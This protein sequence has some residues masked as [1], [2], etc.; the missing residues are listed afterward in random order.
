VGGPGA[1]ASQ[2]AAC[3]PK[4]ED[5]QARRGWIIGPSV[6]LDLLHAGVLDTDLFAQKGDLP[7]EP[8]ELC[9]DAE[10]W[11]EAVSGPG[12]GPGQGEIGEGD[13]VHRRRAD[14]SGPVAG[15]W[16]GRLECDSGHGRPPEET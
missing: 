12:E 7:V 4:F 3:L 11:I 10:P 16:K 9:L 15:L 14:A 8:F 5:G 1:T 6:G 13:G 2:K